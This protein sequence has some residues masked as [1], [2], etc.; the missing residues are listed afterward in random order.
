MHHNILRLT[1]TCILVGGVALVTHAADPLGSLTQLPGSGPVELRMNV[2]LV[3]HTA[4]APGSEPEQPETGPE[5]SLGECIAI[6]LERSPNLRAERASLAASQSGYSALMRFG[7]VG[8][9]V[10]PDLSIRKQ[11]AERGLAAAAASYQKA[12][13][14]VVYDVTRLYYTAVYAKQQEAIAAEVTEY[15]EAMVKLVRTIL[16]TT[17]DP[18]DLAGL[19]EGKWLTMR[20][21]LAQAQELRQTARIGRRQALAALRQVMAV[22]EATFPF[23]IKDTELPLMD[24]RAAFT[25]E[26]VVELALAQ[27]PE[28]ALAAAGVDVFRLEVYAQGR[29]PFRRVVPTF[30]AGADIHS[31][32]IP[33]AV[34]TKEY[35]P[36]AIAPEMPTQLV[37]SKFDRVCRAMNFSE[38]A[39]AIYENARSLVKL[40]AENAFYEY[41]LASQ[42]LRIAE[43]KFKDGKDLQQRTRD[44]SDSVKEKDLLV[45]AYI[46]SIKAQSDYIEAVYQ[47]LLSLAALERITAGGI[48]PKFPGR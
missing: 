15:L 39:D 17:A 44:M 24:Q 32:D 41:E 16:D 25:K 27:R 42:K 45:Q 13:N 21:G 38:K 47:H 26:K 36:G 7:T 1:F 33:Q 6:A 12:H 23:R 22:D 20:I 40:D 31:K 43:R 2:P 29:I 8:T 19:N 11:Q 9:L 30:A 4:Q 5:L 3:G 46:V 48:C 10:S 28:L 18:K 35:R 37:G 34:R 14:E